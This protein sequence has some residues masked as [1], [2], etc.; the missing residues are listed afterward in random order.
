MG[1]EKKRLRTNRLVRA[2]PLSCSPKIPATVG[3]WKWIFVFYIT[4]FRKTSHNYSRISSLSRGLRWKYC[5]I[6]IEST[7]AMLLF[8]VKAVVSLGVVGIA[9]G[10]VPNWM[11]CED[12]ASNALPF[13]DHKLPTSTRVANLLSLMTQDE[14]CQQTYDKMGTIAKVPSWKVPSWIQLEH[15]VLAWPGWDLPYCRRR[16][17]LP[18]CLSGTVI[19]AHCFARSPPAHQPAVS[20]D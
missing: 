1:R 3:S 5:R 8:W 12:A 4:G 7:M 20:T 19:V 6:R 16:Y 17:T 9:A 15:R 10:Q 2:Y 14:L 13:C 11:P 18:L